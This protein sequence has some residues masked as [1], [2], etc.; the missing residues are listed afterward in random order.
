MPK[1]KGSPEKG[2]R[3]EGNQRV[4]RGDYSADFLESKGDVF[5]DLPN[6]MG[7]NPGLWS[8]SKNTG[9]ANGYDKNMGYWS[10][11]ESAKDV[12]AGKASSLGKLQ[13]VENWT[14]E[15]DTVAPHGSVSSDYHKMGGFS[16]DV[17]QSRNHP[18]YKRQPK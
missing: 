13:P 5:A 14:F 17:S 10:A 15:D 8:S 3:S 1:I 12:R 4:S 6:P 16:S 2:T 9:P 7:D 18:K 11:A